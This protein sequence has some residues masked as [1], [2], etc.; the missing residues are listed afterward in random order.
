MC[1]PVCVCVC[2]CL[3]VLLIVWCNCLNEN[4]YGYNYSLA[5][6]CIVNNAEM[7][8]PAGGK[9]HIRGGGYYWG[10]IYYKRWY[11]LVKARVDRPELASPTRYKGATW[12]NEVKFNV[13]MS[14][15]RCVCYPHL[16]MNRFVEFL[17]YSNKVMAYL[18]CDSW[19]TLRP[20]S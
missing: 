17:Q 2:V 12:A 5:Y 13:E 4:C 9:W 6:L 15:D 14:V 7:N 3:Y 8:I 10:F 1:V 16:S 11:L 19:Q 18:C 20:R